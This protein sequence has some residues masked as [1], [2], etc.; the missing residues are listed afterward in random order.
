V[1][2]SNQ[3][4]EVVKIHPCLV[5]YNNPEEGLV[6]MLDNNEFD[7]PA[8]WGIVVADIV[9]HLVNAY[10]KDGMSARETREEILSMFLAEVQKPTAKAHR[11]DAE[12]EEEGF[13]VTRELDGGEE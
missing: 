11:V 4:R 5:V 12:W 2:N 1:S 9:Q 7:T 6:V 13:S 8:I 10:V 3:E